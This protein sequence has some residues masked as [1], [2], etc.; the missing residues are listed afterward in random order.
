[1]MRS[2]ASS[3]LVYTVNRGTICVADGYHVT[4]R[5]RHGRLI[6]EDGFGP[7]RRRREYTRVTTPIARLVVVGNG[8]S[9]SLEALCWLRDLGAALIHV[10][11]DGRLVT[12]TATETPDARL[13]RAQALAATTHT[14]LEIGRS[15]LTEKVRGQQRTLSTLTADPKLLDAMAAAASRLETATSV[16]ELVWAERDAALAYWS[17]WSTVPVRFVPR[18]R[19]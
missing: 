17:S 1:P 12:T 11:R 3:P 19:A 4:V 8:G 14:G 16:D 13:R 6:V 7:D 2:K 9:I 18:D 10:T 5:I 15:I